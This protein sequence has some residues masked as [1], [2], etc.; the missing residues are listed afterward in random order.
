MPGQITPLGDTNTSFELDNLNLRCNL[1]QLFNEVEQNVR[2]RPDNTNRSLNNSSYCA[3]T[4][5]DN[6]FIIYFCLFLLVITQC[7]T[8]LHQTWYNC[9]QCTAKLRQT[10]YNCFQSTTKLHQTWYNCTTPN[11]ANLSGY[12]DFTESPLPIKIL[13]LSSINSKPTY[14][15]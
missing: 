4:N 1:K 8:K 14:C 5:V 2:L 7:T 15:M 6:C 11:L 3:K 12:D 9:F 13:D 10:W